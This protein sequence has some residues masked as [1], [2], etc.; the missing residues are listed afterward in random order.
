MVLMEMFS[1]AGNRTFSCLA[2]RVGCLSRRF[3]MSQRV[4]SMTLRFFFANSPH[5]RLDKAVQ[6]LSGMGQEAHSGALDIWSCPMI[7]FKGT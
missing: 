6:M 3:L 5:L 1:R 4:D 7:F 2:V